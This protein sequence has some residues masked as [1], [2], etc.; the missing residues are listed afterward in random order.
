MS[1][2]DDTTIK[3]WDFEKDFVLIHTF[4]DHV[5]YVMMLAL[6]PRDTNSFCSASLDR[7]IKVY[8][9]NDYLNE[10]VVFEQ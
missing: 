6:N 9:I 10:G 5:H 3:I 8:L 2:S 1:S 4:E 7:S